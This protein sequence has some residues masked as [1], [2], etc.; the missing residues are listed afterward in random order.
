MADDSLAHDTFLFGLPVWTLVDE[1][2]LAKSG[3]PNGVLHV[4]SPQFRILF[5][6]FTDEDLALEFIRDAGV[7]GR[8]PSKI[9]GKNLFLSLLKHFENDGVEYVGI[10]CPPAADRRGR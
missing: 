8:A 7:T 10:D 2:E 9:A 1:A 6:L 4:Q 5:A 3:L